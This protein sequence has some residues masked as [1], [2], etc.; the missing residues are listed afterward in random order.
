MAE[1]VRQRRKKHYLIPREK[2][3][4]R[5]HLMSQTL[6]RIPEIL[7]STCER[8]VPVSYARATDLRAS[9]PEYHQLPQ[10]QLLKAY[11]QDQI[12]QFH[13]MMNYERLVDWTRTRPQAI[14][15]IARRR[16]NHPL[17]R[18]LNEVF[19]TMGSWHACWAIFDTS[20][21]ALKGLQHVPQITNLSVCT[22]VAI[23]PTSV[24]FTLTCALPSWTQHL[25][26]DL[27][28]LPVGSKISRECFLT[29]LQPHR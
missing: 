15:G 28:A 8:H 19:P 16:G 29:L 13:R 23:Q 22:A 12:G 6:P 24:S 7:C 18:Y 27:R 3:E 4:E 10:S 26:A 1:C 14:V 17:Q 9:R 11:Q 2:E 25:M 21:E 5:I 20:C